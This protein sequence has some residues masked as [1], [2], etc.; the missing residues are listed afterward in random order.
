MNHYNENVI[1]VFNSLIDLY[2]SGEVIEYGMRKTIMGEGM[3]MYKNPFDKGQLV[4][5]FNVSFPKQLD[6]SVCSE[7]ESY[8]PPRAEFKEPIDGECLDLT[9]LSP[10][11]SSSRHRNN[12]FDVYEED[13]DEEYE[14]AGAG[15]ARQGMQC[16]SQ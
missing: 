11:A 4:I 2:I 15:G 3:P 1:S 14:E 5:I 7:I 6:P 8:L 10:S 12:Q 13:D 9:D 16:A